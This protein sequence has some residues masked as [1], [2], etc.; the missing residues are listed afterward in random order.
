M[1]Y[2]PMDIINGKIVVKDK[3]LV[4]ID[5]EAVAAKA[6]QVVDHLIKKN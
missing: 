6:N 3:K 2:K 4:N 1:G 5:E